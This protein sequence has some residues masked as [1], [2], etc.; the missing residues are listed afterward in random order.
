MGAFAGL[1]RAAVTDML[2]HG[3]TFTDDVFKGTDKF[4]GTMHGKNVNDMGATADK[5]L[6]TGVTI[7]GGEDL[8]YD[9]VGSHRF[10]TAKDVEHAGPT[11]V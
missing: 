2:I 1:I 10:M 6:G 5:D 9:G 4:L 8:G 11:V 3:T 7:D